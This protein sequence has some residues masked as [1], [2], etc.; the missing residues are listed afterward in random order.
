MYLVVVMLARAVVAIVSWMVFWSLVPTA[1]GWS[2]EVVVSDSMMPRVAAGDVVISQPATADMVK[3]GQVVVVENPARPGTLLMHRL[4]GRYPDGSLR[5]RGDANAEDDSTPVPTNMVRGIPRIR[6]PYVGLPVL[7]QRHGEYALAG[8]AVAVLLSAAVLSAGRVP[9][10]LKPGIDTGSQGRGRH[11]VR[12]QGRRR[13]PRRGGRHGPVLAAS[14]VLLVGAASIGSAQAAF[15]KTTATAANTWDRA[16]VTFAAP[17]SA[18]FSVS[19]ALPGST[20]TACR[21]I[22]YTG[23]APATVRL[24]LSAADLSGT[25]GAYLTLRIT[26]DNDPTHTCANYAPTATLYNSTGMSDAT[27]T[28]SIFSTTSGAYAQGVSEW[29]ATTN[30]TRLYQFTWQLQDDNAAVNRTANATF[31]WEART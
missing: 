7:W 5:T 4:V 23:S 27:K 8:L 10:A 2:A 17:A 25:L 16:T 24:Y 19:G 13:R 31:T 6:I 3:P 11:R 26:E 30:A 15:V 14:A 29:T 22:T 21:Q 20:G 18:M 9:A 1:A 12:R 28:L